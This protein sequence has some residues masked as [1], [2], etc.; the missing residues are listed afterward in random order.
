MRRA[1]LTAAADEL[2]EYTN[3]HGILVALPAPSIIFL[4][5]AGSS[6]PSI[7]IGRLRLGDVSASK[8]VQFQVGE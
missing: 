2:G 7:G 1:I 5:L 3:S 6:D 4:A 8:L